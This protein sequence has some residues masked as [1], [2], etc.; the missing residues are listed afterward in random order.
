MASEEEHR[1]ERLFQAPA[2][3]PRE[4]LGGWV[5]FLPSQEMWGEQPDLSREAWRQ[6]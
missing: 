4:D 3:A 1:G 6:G 2:K 5:G